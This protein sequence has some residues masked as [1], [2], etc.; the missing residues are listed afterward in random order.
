MKI[1]TPIES[2]VTL[3][4]KTKRYLNL[5]FSLIQKTLDKGFIEKG[6]KILE[7]LGRPKFFSLSDHIYKDEQFEIFGKF[8]RA[9]KERSPGGH[10]NYDQIKIL[11]NGQIVFNG[12]VGWP[13]LGPDARVNQTFY[14]SGKWEEEFEALHKKVESLV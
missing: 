2:R 5:D 9:P 12:G 8:G 1:N 4:E 10:Y 3:D 11:Y 6:K 13:N 7:S 14:I